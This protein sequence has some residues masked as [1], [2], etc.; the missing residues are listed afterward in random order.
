MEQSRH[1]QTLAIAGPQA[2]PPAAMAIVGALAAHRALADQ[3]IERVAHALGA[4]IALQGAAA[5]FDKTDYYAREMGPNLQRTFFALDALMGPDELVALK[6]LTW[7]TEQ[8]FARQGCRQVNLDAGYLDATK[9]VLASFKVGPQKLYLGQAV[10]ADL[11]LYFRDG[12]YGPLPWTFPDLRDDTHASFFLA[13]RRQYKALLRQA[14][15]GQT[16]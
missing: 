14:R 8:H 15:H 1:D 2:P 5:A 4:A 12:A 16:G 13:A 7:Q 9:V 6:Q 11:V 10:W 3:A